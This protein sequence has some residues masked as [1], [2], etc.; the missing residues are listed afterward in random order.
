MSNTWNLLGDAASADASMWAS[1]KAMEETQDFA[2]K[3]SIHGMMNSAKDNA[4]SNAASG[5]ATSINQTSKN[6]KESVSNQ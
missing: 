3:T 1:E 5:M 4:A 6:L 2:T